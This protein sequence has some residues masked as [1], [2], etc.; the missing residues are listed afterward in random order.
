MLLLGAIIP[1]ASKALILKPDKGPLKKI[2]LESNGNQN[3]NNERNRYN[4]NG[5]GRGPPRQEPSVP[6]GDYLLLGFQWPNTPVTINIDFS[7]SELNPAEAILDI[8]ASAN[9][10][11]DALGTEIDLFNDE[12]AIIDDGSWDNRAPDFKNELVFGKYKRGVIAVAIVWYD[13]ATNYIVEFDIMFNTRFTWSISDDCD[14]DK[15]DLWNI[16]T[17][18]LGHGLGLGDLYDLDNSEE[19]MYGYSDYGDIE[20]RDLD[21]G[22]KAGIQELYG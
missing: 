14:S 21:E 17:H 9:A 13:S 22:D 1:I 19:T 12:I 8:T 16:A 11:D 18:E 5:K 3:W 10:W 6:K 2:I 20:K 15:M 4:N 7:G